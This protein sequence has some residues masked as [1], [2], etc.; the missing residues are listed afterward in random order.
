MK[1]RPKLLE[2]V[3]TIDC[4]TLCTILK[5]KYEP[6]WTNGH[7]QADRETKMER[8]IAQFLEYF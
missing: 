5:H 8:T 3:W 6:F 7:E 4:T 1:E 2:Y